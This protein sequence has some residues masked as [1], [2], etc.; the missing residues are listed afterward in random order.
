MTDAALPLFGDEEHAGRTELNETFVTA[1]RVPLD[2][3]SW[4]EHVPG[5]LT[6]A[7]RL[8]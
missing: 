6:G 8:F 2:A 5:W 7:E 4:V 1:H 3:Q